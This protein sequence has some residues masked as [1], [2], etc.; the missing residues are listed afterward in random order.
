MQY[1]S[2]HGGLAQQGYPISGEFVEIS[3]LIGKPYLV[4]YFERSRLEIVKDADSTQHVVLGALGL[5]KYMQ[6][7]GKLP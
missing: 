1:W 3:D 7:Y 5:E 4:Q 6:R 2:D